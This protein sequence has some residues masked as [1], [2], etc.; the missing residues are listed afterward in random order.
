M[1][2]RISGATRILG[3]SQGYFALPIRDEAVNCSANGNVP[4]MVSAWEPTPDEML[5][6]ASGGALYLRVLGTA[7]PP[8]MM[9]VEPAQETGEA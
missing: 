9:W 2:K 4:S 6:L 7:H 8:V 5:M 1:L 3:Q